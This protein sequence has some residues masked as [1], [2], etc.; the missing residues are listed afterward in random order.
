[1]DVN[2]MRNSDAG[3][4]ESIA[5]ELRERV[6][7]LN[8]LFGVSEIVERSGRSLD[9][10]LAETVDL[11]PT[12]WEHS[13]VAGARIVLGDGEFRSE[14]F[15]ESPWKLEAEILVHGEGVGAIEL[16]YVEERPLRS[17]GPFSAEER[18]VLNAVAERLGH[19]VERLRAEARLRE[20]E[21]GLRARITHLTRVS[22][23]GEMASSIAHEVNQP[24]TAI[25]TYAQACRRLAQAGKADDR[26]VLEILYRIADEALRAG[27][28]IHRLRVL[29]R[30]RTSKPSE[31]DI[32]QLLKEITPLASADARLHD[33]SLR[34]SL[35]RTLPPILADGIQ[36]QQV[37]LNLIRNGIDAIEETTTGPRNLQV[38]VVRLN[39]K[40]AQVSVRDTGCGLPEVSET[41]LFEPFFTTKEWGMGMGLSISKSIIAAHGGRLWYSRNR[42]GGTTFL[43]TLPLATEASHD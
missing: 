31:C 2:R 32:L 3:S 9:R 41:A 17:E 20:E 12:A 19:V 18:R 22:T 8:C 35:P 30:R 5:R 4:Q 39:G 34:F 10:I 16:V 38:R 24:L 7:E 13:D 36:I 43:F 29:M 21:A 28:I 40:E 42:D 14:G 25:A 27:H 1:L 23:M 6:R 11:L 15:A 37:M 26:E 33:V